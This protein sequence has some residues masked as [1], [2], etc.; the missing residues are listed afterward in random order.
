MISPVPPEREATNR[1]RRALRRRRPLWRFLEALCP[2]A[3]AAGGSVHLVGGFVRDLIE[4]RPGKDVDLMVTGIGFDA[5]GEVLHSLP[6]G[7]LGIRRI[8]PAG[9]QFAV[10]KVYAAW[11]GEALDV[12]LARSERSTGPGHR[13]FD[14]S[15]EGVGALEDAS[16]RDFTINSLMFRLAPGGGGLRGEVIDHFGGISDLRRRRIRGVGNPRDRFRED[17]LRILR[18]IRLKNE[19]PGFAI[20]KRTWAALRGEAPARVGRVSAERLIAELSRSLAANP[21]G[22]IS[23]LHRSGILAALL[24]EIPDWA[25]GALARMKRRYRVLEESLGSPLPEAPMLANLLVDVAEREAAEILAGG[26]H[27]AGAARGGRLLRLA[28]TGAAARRLHFP[29]VRKVV[30]LL[31][32]LIR[33]IRLPAGRNAGIEALFSRQE[34]PRSLLAL[35]SA[36]QKATSRRERDFRSLLRRA[37]AIPSLLSGD[38]VVAMGV[39][40]GPLVESILVRVREATLAGDVTNREE[41]ARLAALLYADDRVTRLLHRE[42]TSRGSAGR[43]PKGEGKAQGSRA[44][45]TAGREPPRT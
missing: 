4:G 27:A 44:L 17:P 6:A 25:S 45:R 16:R 22:T 40:A 15:T 8:L 41:A 26:R 42:R 24:P 43:S 33:L 11:S 37:A 21:L 1:V 7:D 30:R 35:Y 5:L 31:E 20:E 10:Y 18:A 13:H 32:D 36:A 23:D 29:R 34:D 14:I 9:K 39:P 28:R 12:A 19:R 38:D 3:D 2:A